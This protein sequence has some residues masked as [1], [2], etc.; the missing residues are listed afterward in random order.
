MRGLAGPRL[1]E[2]DDPAIRRLYSYWSPTQHE[3]AQSGYAPDFI[4]DPKAAR[5]PTRGRYKH[6]GPYK[7]D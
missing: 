2:S 5:G 4:S 1:T 7:Q 6:P 3:W